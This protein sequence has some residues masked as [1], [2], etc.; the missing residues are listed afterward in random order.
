M[1][2]NGPRDKIF[3]IPL[4]DTEKVDIKIYVPAIRAQGL[5]LTPWAS[6]YVLAGILYK[7]GI[8]PVVP[9]GQNI[10]I[11]ELGAGIG[12]VGLVGSMIWQRQVILTDLK[13]IVPGLA[14][15]IDLNSKL[16]IDHKGSADAGE[17]DWDKPRDLI[18]Q[19]GTRLDSEK[20]KASIIIA[21]DT[22]YSDDHP[23]ML[24]QTILEWL[25]PGPQSRFILTLPL[26]VA[27]LDQIRH[28]W[29]LLE[30]GG[31]ESFAE[32]KEEAAEVGSDAWDDE[33][34][35]EWSIWRWKETI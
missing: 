3:K 31:L 2:P 1:N 6:T 22:I 13:P 11:L 19:D 5:D 14:V 20:N 12:L 25:A 15:N 29:E 26:R 21:A 17:L 23:P 27:Y 35:C 24:A 28:L 7:L 16:L 32:G 33:K 8:E 18:L 9:N 30:Q 4:S 34:L 10:H